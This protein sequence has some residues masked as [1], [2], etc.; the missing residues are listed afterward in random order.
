MGIPAQHSERIMQ[1]YLHELQPDGEAL[2][3]AADFEGLRCLR[4]APHSPLA[5]AARARAARTHGS[6]LP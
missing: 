3:E 1:W 6:A 4:A 5:H 2:E